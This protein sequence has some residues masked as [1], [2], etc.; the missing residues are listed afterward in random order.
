M[1][2]TRPVLLPPLTPAH[3]DREL[4]LLRTVGRLGL[5]TAPLTRTLL[6]PDGS[7][8]TAQRLLRQLTERGY[9]L[10]RALPR[11]SRLQSKRTPPPA[12]PIGYVLAQAG[13]MLLDEL[14]AEPDAATLRRLIAY[15]PEASPA[16]AE[17]LLADH[18]LAAFCT[19]AIAELRRSP[20]VASI[21]CQRS[22]VVSADGV[23]LA[24]GA[25][26]TIALDR[27]P[28]QDR[29]AR[30]A[31][32]VDSVHSGQ[33][34]LVVRLGIELDLGQTPKRGLME[35]AQVY[36]RA[37]QGRVFAQVLGGDVRPVLI[38]PS[39]E[40]L[41]EVVREAWRAAWPQTTAI[42][43][44]DAEAAHETYGVLWGRYQTVKDEPGVGTC[45]LAPHV[46]DLNLWMS[47]LTSPP[48]A[49]Q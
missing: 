41:A 5:I 48:S 39:M 44:K 23:S 37:T 13:R 47:R 20:Y 8:D 35:Q 7:E 31:P 29:L 24:I 14:G 26:L 33:N 36:A 16:S 43:A 25:L 40:G 3:G 1:T 22:Q 12:K 46:N 21:Q 45:L 2:T 38:V 18:F 28:D 10:R 17:K 9:L 11:T 19:S 27:Q 15:Y 4:L 34:W 32:W 6:L 49:D 30:L 42:I